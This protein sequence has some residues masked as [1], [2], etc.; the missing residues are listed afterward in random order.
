M[1]WHEL[2][3]AQAPIFLLLKEPD[4]IAAQGGAMRREYRRHWTPVHL[5]FV[6]PDVDAA[7]AKAAAAGAK[8]EGPIQSYVWGRQAVFSDPFGHGLCFVQWSGGGYDEVADD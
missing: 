5:D 6:V 4:T 1:G 2:S 3:G 8:L 7:A